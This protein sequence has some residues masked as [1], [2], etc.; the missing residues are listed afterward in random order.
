MP[1]KI[2]LTCLPRTTARLVLPR[3]KLKINAFN[4]VFQNLVVEIP[5]ILTEI[6]VKMVLLAYIE[7]AFQ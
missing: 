1:A 5:N 4:L 3:I 7:D 2:V 6:M